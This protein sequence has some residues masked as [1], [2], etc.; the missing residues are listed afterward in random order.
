MIFAGK[1]RERITIQE[2]SVGR[3][4]NGEE[5]ITWTN[6]IANEPAEVKV[7]RGR[8]LVALRAALSEL[9]LEVRIRYRSGLNTTMRITWQGNPYYITEMLP[10][11]K[12]NKSE[13]T[14]MCAGE[15]EDAVA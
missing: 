9:A 8:E 6:V 10:G 7:L 5:V 2:K 14:L 4:A 12:A 1:L 15:S 13:I 3:A 11:G